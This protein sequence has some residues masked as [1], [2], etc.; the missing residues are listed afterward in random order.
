M[1]EANSSDAEL[2]G[3]LDGLL[4]SDTWWKS[5]LGQ[6]ANE[7][8]ALKVLD[9]FVAS[10]PGLTAFLRKMPLFWHTRKS[11]IQALDR[12]PE[13]FGLAVLASTSYDGFVR[14]RA[15]ENLAR[16]GGRALPYLLLRTTDWVS[17]VHFRAMKAV[18]NLMPNASDEAV[19]RSLDVLPWLPEPRPHRSSVK[20]WLVA[21][22]L[23]RSGV[24]ATA[25]SG[26]NEAVRAYFL[27]NEM[28]DPTEDRQKV[29]LESIKSSP[30]V[31][32]EA[33]AKLPTLDM[34]GQRQGLDVLSRK[35]VG[36]PKLRGS[37]M[38]ALD[39]RSWLIMLDLADRLNEIDL[40][41]EGTCHKRWRIRNDARFLLERRGEMSF[42]HHYRVRFPAVGA[43]LGFGEAPGADVDDLLPFLEHPSASTRSAAIISLGRIGNR[44]LEDAI[45]LH[46]SDSSPRVIRATIYALKSLKVSLAAAKFEQAHANVNQVRARAALEMGIDLVPRW[47]QIALLLDWCAKKTLANDAGRALRR[48]LGRS[49]S[50]VSHP[51][52]AQLDLIVELLKQAD[53]Q[54][55]LKAELNAEFQYQRKWVGQA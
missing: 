34:E 22:A 4:G 40:L 49:S 53:V 6:E 39:G 20:E 18:E 51:T 28:Y 27:K 32:R 33:I 41:W 13:A 7:A 50:N 1:T 46:L 43:I 38:S 37:L 52:S 16:Q 42:L 8:A 12:N 31:S 23:R 14:E 55:D 45:V 5:I 54:A 15:V 30:V 29:I 21:E 44:A 24:I 11:A 26:Q 3:A 2:Q 19:I 36:D 25:R 48:W 35:D 17:E 47:D 9:D 10:T